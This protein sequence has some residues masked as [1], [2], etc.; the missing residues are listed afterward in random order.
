MWGIDQATVD[1]RTLPSYAGICGG[2]HYWTA[3]SSV[4]AWEEKP[5]RAVTQKR[6]Q[7]WPFELC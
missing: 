6:T 4:D 3:E 1:M 5:T 7:L 2:F